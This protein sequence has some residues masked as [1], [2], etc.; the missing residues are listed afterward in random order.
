MGEY[1][2]D[3]FIETFDLDEPAETSSIRCLITGDER[4]P[5]NAL[6]ADDDLIDPPHKPPARDHATLWLDTAE[7]AYNQWFDLLEFAAQQ[8]LEVSILGNSY[9]DLDSTVHVVF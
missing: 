8:N 2:R 5:H 4:V 9:Y 7:S 1:Q 3:Q 6:E